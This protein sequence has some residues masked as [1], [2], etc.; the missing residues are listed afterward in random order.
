MSSNNQI[1]NPSE[2]IDKLCIRCKIQQ[3]INNFVSYKKHCKE[4]IN[5]EQIKY[6]KINNARYYQTNKG[7]LKKINLQNYYIKKNKNV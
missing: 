2:I 4:C 7:K 5:K 6:S 1:I 3:D